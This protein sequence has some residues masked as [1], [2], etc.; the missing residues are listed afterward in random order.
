MVSERAEVATSRPRWRQIGRILGF[1]AVLVCVFA[2][3]ALIGLH[4][5][6][7]RRFVLRQVTQLLAAQRIELGTDGLRYNLLDLSLSL[8]NIR[9]RSPEAPKA[10]PFAVIRSARVDLSLMQL[11]RGRYLV[12]SSALEGV[13]IHYFVDA[14]GHDNLPRPPENPDQPTEPLDYLV[15]QLAANNAS[16]RY[17]NRAQAIDLTLPV[18]SLTVEGDRLTDRHDVFLTARAGHLRIQDRSTTLDTISAELDLGKDDADVTRLDVDAAGSRVSVSG[19]VRQFDAPVADLAVRAHLD[20]AHVSPL[21]G[22][23]DPTGGEVDIDA[24][25]KGPV[26]AP[27]LDARVSGSEL[28]FRNV[29]RMQLTATTVYD[30][31]ARRAAVS[32][33]ELQAPWGALAAEGTVAVASGTSRVRA[34]IT[35]V[36]AASL[37]RALDMPYVAASLLNG[38]V[39]GEWPALD[40]LNATGAANFTLTPSTA[41]VRQSALPVRGRLDVNARAGRAVARLQSF[42][43]GG[44]DVSGRVTLIDRQRLEG[45]LRT[46]IADV[47]RTVTIAETFL[48]R[49]RGSL[50][51]TPVAGSMAMDARLGGTIE[52]PTV[53]AGI[54]A[55]HLAVGNAKGLAVTGDVAYAPAGVTIDR[56]DLAWQQA[57]AH[58]AGRIGLV[59]AQPLALTVDADAF[60]VPTLLDA[61]NQTG[62]P[63]SGSVSLQG[64]VSGTLHRPAA[65]MTLQ[66]SNLAAYN[67]VLGS[68]TANIRM[69][70]REVLVDHLLLDKPQ[71]EGNGRLSGTARYHLDR[72]TYTFDLRSQDLRLLGLAP[73]P[74]QI[75][76]GDVELVARGTGSVATPA[77]DINLVFDGLR[78]ARG[79]TEH[80]LGRVSVAAVVANQ[81]AN[82]TAAADRFSVDAQATVGVSAPYPATAKLRVDGLDLAALPIQLETPLSGELRATVDGAG[83]LAEPT[84]GRAIATI[85]AFQGSWNEQPFRVDGPATL[86]YNQERLAIER[87]RLTAQDSSVTVNG[88]LPV[89][90]RAGTGTIE[91]EAQANL[92]TLA[93]YAP[94]GTQISGDGNVALT[95]SLR[96]TL[97]AIDP[98]LV[99][100]VDNGVVLSPQLEPSISNLILRARV[101]GGEADI[102]RLAANWGSARLEASGK[103]PLEVLPPLPVELARHGGPATF[104]ASIRELDPAVLPGTPDGVTGRISIDVQ[105]AAARADLMALEGR[106]SLP[107]LEVA[108]NRL[109]LAQQQPS[110][111][112]ISNGTATVEQFSLSGSIG[113]LAANGT[114]GLA[115]DRALDVEA[116]GKLNIAAVSF[117]TDAVRA[118]GITTL[119]V[120]ARG[121]LDAPE[122][123]GYVDLANA[124]VVIDEPTIAAE[125]LSARV[126]LSGQRMTLTS[127]TGEINGGQLTGSGFA[128]LGDGGVSDVDLQFS[129]DDFAFD[130]PLDLRS[131]SDSKIRV[132]RRGDE[133]FVDGQVRI[134]EAGLTG[135]VN[136]D[137]GLLAAMTARRTL[138]LTEERSPLLQRVRFNINVDT[139]TPVLVDNNLAKAEIGVDVRVVGTVYE[140]GLS[141]RLTVLEGGEITLNERRYEVERGVITFLDERRIYPSFDLLL[142]TSAGN[143]DITLAVTGTPGETET[144]LTAD[145]TLPEPDIMAML[146][147]G[148][149]LDEMRGQE[150]EVAREQ[151]LSY[152]TGR[153]GSTLGRGIERASGLSEVRIEPNLIA[154]EADPGARLTVGQEI[155][156]ELSLVYSSNLTD[157]SDQIWVAEYDLTRRFQ[158]R[159]VRQSDDS[160]RVDFRHDV[161]I[162]GQPAPRRLPRQR[163][164]LTGI[165]VTADRVANEDQLRELLHLEED[166][167]YDF[168]AA[169]A[170]V[171]RIEEFYRERG[172]LQS[173]VRLERKADAQAVEVTLRVDPGPQVEMR[174]DGAALPASV[175]ED[176]RLQ[177]HRGVFDA[178]RADDGLETIKSWLMD[179]DYLQPTIDHTVDAVGPQ[180]RRVV[181]RI[182]PGTRFERVTLAFQGASGVDPGVLDDIIEEQKLERQL[183]TDPIVVTELLERYYRE[184]GFLA[185]EIDQPRYEFEGTL[186][187]VV[188]DVREGPRFSV[189]QV[190]MTGN[191]VI[192]TNELIGELPVVAGD[193]FLPAAAERALERVRDLYWRRGH[194]DVRSDYEMVTNRD[195][196]TVDVVVA[197]QEGPQSVI[198]DIAIDGNQKTSERLVREQLELTPEQPL[199]L[200]ALSRSRKNL[201]ETGAFSIVDIT[202]DEVAA[203]AASN[204]TKPV[205]INVAVREVQP[206]Q[207]TY[208]ASYDTERGVGGIFDIS[209]RNSLGKA[210]VVGLSSRYDGQ[211]REVRTYM[212]QPS[213]RYFPIQTTASLYYREERN[214][215]T[216]LTQGFNITRQGLSVQQEKELGNSYVWNYGYRYER[217]RTVDPSPGGILDETITVAPLTSTF[218]REVRDGVLDASRGSFTSQAFAYSPSWLGAGQPYLRYLG[219]YFHYVPLRP[220]QRKRF[221]NEIL[222]PRFVYAGGVRLGLARGLGGSVPISERFY[223]GGS[224]TL[225]GFE[226]NAVGPVGPD[227]IPTGGDALFLINNELRFPLV[228][229]FDGV[230]F[231]DIGN[232]FRRV[233]DFSFT[234]LRKSAGV[235]VRVRTP[236]FLLRGDYGLVLDQR[237][238][239]RRGRFY[240][241]IGQAF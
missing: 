85:D 4:T 38:Q 179:H 230:V 75:V 113:T 177:W 167:P 65:E 125:Q 112:S 221:S 46:R 45:E 191:T 168:F 118:E 129:T 104:N 53:D 219:Q 58:V 77:A 120:A 140:T 95:G 74:E 37:M 175:R 133:F 91:L 215:S 205:H 209:N 5:P 34:D 127:L 47:G 132:T 14:R 55:P 155:T 216:A 201:Y 159:A 151:V 102:E 25:V 111:I 62:I 142:N 100:T 44:A 233:S 121:T 119:Q 186:A 20:V 239:E 156:D 108:F 60:E 194:N 101:A 117:F 27:R 213:L 57:R 160:Y 189:R 84:H 51:P 240:F 39:E 40:Y 161:R 164:I 192:P 71:P 94:A 181:F 163:P 227:G 43:A 26:T 200:G 98:D 6:P 19:S 33:L 234:D 83:D 224:T 63:A 79:S 21:A 32:D 235:G 158:T 162:G 154:N 153:V 220:P 225:R 106:V 41:R 48:G 145:P 10:P 138:D 80:D 180:L 13:Y 82:I 208:G 61:F 59:G 29:D 182:T 210:R 196:G 68:L 143:Y 23:K 187:R 31:T 1:C 139:A 90:D 105:V 207:L 211:L 36:D 173:R 86:H 185:A 217:V 49:R 228:R 172:Y 184:Q 212:G 193:P 146:V 178:Q 30:M 66:A 131:L 222:R 123:N 99:L 109:T 238:G 169:R 202:R 206:V 42:S 126:D 214:P 226:Q 114:V 176:V 130:A 134:D 152:L 35:S 11:L 199:D 18:P 2:A 170:G 15:A 165:A 236:W 16:L 174:F 110:L 190:A 203:E 92:A 183:F 54:S 232:V 198:A 157:S 52:K 3:A 72:Q 78:M 229:I 137:T 128:V 12:E 50:L 136:F 122:L 144:T 96:G 115:G 166:K 9:V 218:T 107:Q 148:R 76:R 73:T 241:S 195:L 56:L 150:Y 147:T 69:A 116:D 87:L 188:L 141:G 223:A 97:K 64:T 135:D 17:E 22:V 81:Q 93:R 88:D 7:G 89:T 237:A 171:Q 124:T 197:I 231:T 24:T 8:R 204:G 70:G 28:K 149:T 67:E 103:I